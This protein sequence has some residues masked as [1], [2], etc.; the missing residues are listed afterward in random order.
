MGERKRLFNRGRGED[1]GKGKSKVG[2]R[3]RRKEG[4]EGRKNDIEGSWWNSD[5]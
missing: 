1:G 2:W 3:K 5:S 4:K